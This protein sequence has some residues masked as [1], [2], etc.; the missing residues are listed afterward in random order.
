MQLA[1]AALAI[2]TTTSITAARKTTTSTLTIMSPGLVGLVLV[3]VGL[4][5]LPR[6]PPAAK[7]RSR[8]PCEETEEKRGSGRMSCQSQSLLMHAIEFG[9]SLRSNQGEFESWQLNSHI[10]RWVYRN[11]HS[12]DFVFY[13]RDLRFYRGSTFGPTFFRA[14]HFWNHLKNH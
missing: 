4:V 12:I 13:L 9:F 14:T 2:T 7:R 10:I 11:I 1:S 8:R 6:R 5:G 3:L